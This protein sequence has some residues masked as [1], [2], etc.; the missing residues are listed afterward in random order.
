MADH[1]PRGAEGASP[2]PASAPSTGASAYG[3]LYERHALELTERDVPVRGL[4]PALVGPAHRPASPT[5]TAA[6][7]CR[8]TMSRAAVD[9]AD[10]ANGPI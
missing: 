5:S 10:G 7:G 4:P 1:P 2:R 8:T 3:Y 6:A 9:D